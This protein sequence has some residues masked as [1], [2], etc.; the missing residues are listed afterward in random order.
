MSK[1]LSYATFAI[2]GK[3]FGILIQDVQEILRPLEVTKVPL[4]SLAFNGLINLR[5]NIV[6][7]INMRQLLGFPLLETSNC[8]NIVLKLQDEFYS[9]Q[10]DSVA[11]VVVVHQ[12]DFEIPPE[13]LPV[14][15][16]RFISG[17]YKLENKLLHVL[18]I[19]QILEDKSLSI[20][21][22]QSEILV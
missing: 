12:A 10:V 11:D 17:T 4:A 18:D 2:G 6:L 20:K 5:G 9:L 1:E 13:T 21:E 7:A 19:G 14:E 8:M 15:T 16:R 3:L 22:K